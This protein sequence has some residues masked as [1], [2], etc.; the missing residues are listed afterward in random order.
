MDSTQKHLIFVSPHLLT[1]ATA[2][3]ILESGFLAEERQSRTSTPI[4]GE[5]D[6]NNKTSGGKDQ[7]F[8][9]LATAR[10]RFYFK[11]ALLIVVSKYFLSNGFSKIATIPYFM[12]SF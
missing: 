1:T 12:A 7:L 3:T 5:N 2:L 11:S 9:P 4:P 6:G 8:K 10:P